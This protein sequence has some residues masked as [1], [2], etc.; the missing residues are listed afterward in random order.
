MPS[1]ATPTPVPVTGTTTM[2]LTTTITREAATT[3]TQAS[4]SPVFGDWGNP[5]CQNS[6][7][8]IPDSSM[9]QQV[10]MAKEYA[11]G[12]DVEWRSI[13]LTGCVWG[14]HSVT[15]RTTVWW[16]SNPGTHSR[17]NHFYGRVCQAS[18][19]AT[20]TMQVTTT[21]PESFSQVSGLCRNKNADDQWDVDVYGAFC[22][23][24][25]ASHLDCQAACSSYGACRAAGSYGGCDLFTDFSDSSSMDCPVG[26]SAH[27]ARGS[28][29]NLHPEQ[30]FGQPYQSHKAPRAYC[31]IKTMP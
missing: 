5:E 10:A 13:T 18:S 23:K 19:A 12:G 17:N 25:S 7:L 24:T 22:Y 15:G 31:F 2:Q 14:T 20:T 21:M 9:C 28:A 8:P 3:T 16:K 11:W 1:S 4:V 30:Y 27:P 29:Q 6:S 26:F